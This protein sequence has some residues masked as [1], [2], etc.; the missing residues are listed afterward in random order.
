MSFNAIGYLATKSGDVSLNQLSIGNAWSRVVGTV[1]LRGNNLYSPHGTEINYAPN[2][3]GAL[4]LPGILVRELVA[5]DAPMTVRA[6]AAPPEIRSG[7]WDAAD[8]PELYGESNVRFLAA[9]AKVWKLAGGSG[10]WTD[11]QLDMIDTIIKS[12]L[13]VWPY[14]LT[15][16]KNSM[17]D[18][19]PGVLNIPAAHGAAFD[20]IVD[21]FKPIRTAYY[22]N[23]LSDAAAATEASA[24]DVAF[25]DSVHAV[26][27]A[28]ADAP[29]AIAGAVS[30]GSMGLLW[31]VIKKAWPLLLTIGAG[32]ALYYFGPILL[33]G[34]KGA[35]ARKV[36]AN[37]PA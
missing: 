19:P 13:A 20:K 29:A 12:G 32:L 14:P 2:I 37:G 33:T 3:G 26:V 22:R 21:H 16:I 5:G 18:A 15:A 7:E 11:H 4:V 36:G 17:P 24:A 28:V 6:N 31:G 35:L 1:T 30:N 10:I 9:L 27:Q 23:A 34:A 8:L 25:W